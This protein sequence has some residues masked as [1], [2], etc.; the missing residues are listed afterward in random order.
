MENVCNCSVHNCVTS[1][2]WKVTAVKQTWRKLL[3]TKVNSWISLS[4]SITKQRSW[5]LCGVKFCQASLI[6][7]SVTLKISN[8]TRFWLQELGELVHLS[9]SSLI[10]NCFRSL[11]K[12]PFISRL[13]L[14]TFILHLLDLILPVYRIKKPSTV[15]NLLPVVVLNRLQLRHVFT[16]SSLS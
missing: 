3:E 10:A 13:Y 16:F 2:G 12:M 11:K 8:I 9:V 1:S 15:K 4:S 5:F 14:F 7:D 6:S